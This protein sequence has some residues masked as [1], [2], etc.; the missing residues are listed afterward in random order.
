MS[1]KQRSGTVALGPEDMM[2]KKSLGSVATG[3][4]Q[5]DKP[6]AFSVANFRRKLSHAIA[7]DSK[8]RINSAPAG[9]IGETKGW[10][11]K[12]RAPLG[13]DPAP[14]RAAPTSKFFG[15]IGTMGDGNSADESEAPQ[16]DMRATMAASR[17]LI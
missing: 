2:N 12:P 15:T 3:T 11:G 5:Q 7:F 1:E 14:I 9:P 17:G 8:S 16:V 4:Q 6:R 10:S 13:Q